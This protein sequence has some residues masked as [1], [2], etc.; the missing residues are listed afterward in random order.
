MKKDGVRFNRSDKGGIKMALEDNKNIKWEINTTEMKKYDIPLLSF[1]EDY[2]EIDF[3]KI[4]KTEDD[5]TMITIDETISI[6]ADN[7]KPFLNMLINTMVDY[8]K[9]Y[10]NGKGLEMPE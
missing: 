6:D 5:Q 4:S 7:M 3:A 1:T 9:K 10:N 8:E 2:L